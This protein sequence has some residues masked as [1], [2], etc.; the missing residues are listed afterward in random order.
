MLS[1]VLHAIRHEGAMFSS[2]EFDEPWCVDIPKGTDLAQVLKPGAQNV[3][4]CHTV[5]EG[6]CWMQIP[7]GEVLANVRFHFSPVAA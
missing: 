3:V 4:I 5:L 7:R 2:G 1:D 6:R